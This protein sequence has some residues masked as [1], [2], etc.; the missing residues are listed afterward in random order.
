MRGGVSVFLG[1]VGAGGEAC[2]FL[3]GAV[4]GRGLGEAELFGQGLDGEFVAAQVVDGQVASQVVLEFLEA[5]AFFAQVAAQGLRADVQ[6]AG[7]AVQVGP[8]GA[9]AAEQAADAAGQAVAAIGAGQQVGGR[10]FEE[11]LEGAFVL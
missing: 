11:L 5:G 9:V 8:V 7:D 4:E 3:E 10:V 2:P 1:A 6:L